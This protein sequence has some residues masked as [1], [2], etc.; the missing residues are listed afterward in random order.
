MKRD[1]PLFC[2]L[3]IRS[4][5]SRAFSE[6]VCVCV[7]WYMVSTYGSVCALQNS[8]LEK[9]G[10][11]YHEGWGGERQKRHGVGSAAVVCVC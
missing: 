11:R 1:R 10:E 9:K 8:K 3:V 7:Q 6:C 2:F 5:N 4:F